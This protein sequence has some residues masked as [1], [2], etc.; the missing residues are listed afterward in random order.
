[1]T[2]EVAGGIEARRG[3]TD[4]TAD[5]RAALIRDNPD[6]SV[7]GAGQFVDITAG[8]LNPAPSSELTDNSNSAPSTSAS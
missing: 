7:V 5:C 3:D 4:G 1:M 2:G 8:R 6:D